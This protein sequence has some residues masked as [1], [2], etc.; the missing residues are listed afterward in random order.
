LGGPLGVYGFAALLSALGLLLGATHGEGTTVIGVV[1]VSPAA[2]AGLREGDRIT[3]VAGRR[4]AVP[5]DLKAALTA[6]AGTP[7]EVVIERGGQE[8]RLQV[9]L[10]E[11]KRLGVQLGPDREPL[12]VGRAVRDGVA[13][14]SQ[15]LFGGIT[16]ITEHAEVRFVGPVGLTTVTA[17]KPTFGDRLLTAGA[18]QGIGVAFFLLGSFALWPPRARRGAELVSAGTAPSSPEGTD[19]AG[20]P[21]VRLVARAIDWSLAAFVLTLA[22]PPATGLLSFLWFPVEALLLCSWGFTPGK[23]LLGI[24]VRDAQGQ[25]PTFRSAFRRAAVVWAYGVGADTPFALATAV[26]AYAGL[27]HNGTTYWDTLGGYT[28]HHRRVGVA[29]VGIGVVALLGA[30]VATVMVAATE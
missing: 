29:R 27:K 23:W 9:P 8:V 10:G 1:S 2:T 25:R 5:G 26:L 15:V 21:G 18:V 19:I 11:S 6:N 4:V 7:V 3:M 13:Y 30:L 12:D 20:R 22:A 24:A 17:R 28:V 14:P 16:A